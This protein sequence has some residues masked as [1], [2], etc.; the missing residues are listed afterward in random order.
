[1]REKALKNSSRF[2]GR[3]SYTNLRLAGLS[4]NRESAPLVEDKAIEF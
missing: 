1:M 2:F 3:Q 4:S